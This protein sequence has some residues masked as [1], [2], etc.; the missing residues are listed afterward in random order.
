MTAVKQG[1]SIKVHYIG[2][3]DDGTQFDTSVGGDPLEVTV[4]SGQ[5]I[6]GFDAA[7][8]GMLIGDKKAVALSIE[9]AYGEVISQ[10]IQDVDRSEIPAEIDLE[11]GLQLQV[12]GPDGQPFMLTVT[13]LTEEIV[14]LDGNH[15]LAGKAL[16][17]Q[18]ELVEISA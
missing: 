1:D 6:P 3:L 5:V 9:E 7:L 2:T 11:L 18:L 14:T 8:E 16:N 4:G 13:A 12:D 17:F 15:P 10:L